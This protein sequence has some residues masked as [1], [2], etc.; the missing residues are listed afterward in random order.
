MRGPVPADAEIRAAAHE[1][2][3]SNLDLLR[4]QRVWALPFLALMLGAS[5]FLAVTQASAWWVVVAFSAIL[6]AV[7]L[8]LPRHLRRRAELLQGTPQ[9]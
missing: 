8:Y 3:T 2:A 7:H 5:L 4:R 9:A 6:G 1:L